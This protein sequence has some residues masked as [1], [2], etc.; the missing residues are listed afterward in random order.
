[1]SGETEAQIS[2]WTVDT[3]HTHFIRQLELLRAS[4]A[5][6]RHSDEQ[7]RK[8]AFSAQET[9]MQAALTSAQKAV[10]AAMAAQ[11]KATSVANVANEKRFDSV[12]EFRGQQAD[13]LRVTMP[14]AEAEAII[15]RATERI[16]E[17]TSAMGQTVTRVE[18][19]AQR[20]RDQ[21]RYAE[22]A[23]RV[24]KAESA[25][26]AAQASKAQIIAVLS[27]A[28]AIIVATVVVANFIAK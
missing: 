16:Q 12:N 9:A 2:G 22:L 28:C 1:V 13:I 11:E 19:E 5:E 20:L 26:L 17:L 8:I 23:T 27:I 21:E 24:T 7:A 3:L 4:I 25:A 10:E 18:L 15:Q 6:W 14:R